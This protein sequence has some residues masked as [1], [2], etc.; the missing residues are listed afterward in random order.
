[1]RLKSVCCH[2][3]LANDSAST[4]RKIGRYDTHS[5]GS[6]GSFE[7][8]LD[9]EPPIST[10]GDLT[11]K[12]PKNTEGFVLFLVNLVRLVVTLFFGLSV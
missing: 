3:V 12:D 7:P 10:H 6:C 1:M 11:T 4:G 2:F 9:P 5:G 8:G